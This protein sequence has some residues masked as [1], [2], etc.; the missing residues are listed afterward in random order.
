MTASYPTSTPTTLG[1]F[2]AKNNIL[3]ETTSPIGAGDTTIPILDTTD[4]PNS[5]MLTFT[6][7]NEVILYTGK[8]VSSITGVTRGYDGTSAFA[9]GA[10]QELEMR[11]NAEYHN[12]QNEEIVAVAADL[13]N[14]FSAD[15]DDTVVAVGVAT[16]IENRL[17][18]IATQ[19]K[20]IISGTDWKDSPVSSLNGLNNSK[21]AKAGDT[22]TGD[23]TLDNQHAVV[24]NELSSNGTEFVSILAPAAIGTSYSLYLPTGQGAANTSIFND[25][26]G[27]LSFGLI[28]NAN[29]HAS[30]A[31]AYSKLN[32]SAS[33]VNADIAAGAAIALNKL[34]AIT[35]N[36]MVVSDASGFLG[37][38]A[39]EYISAGGH[40]RTGSEGQ[41]QFQDSTTTQINISA[42][43][44]ISGAYS[45]KLPTAQGG[46]A[47]LMENDGSGNLSWRSLTNYITNAMIN[48]SAAIALTKLAAVTASRMLVSDGSGFI[49]A[50][51]W[52][53][54]SPHL[55]TQSGGT[56]RFVDSGSNYIQVAAPTTISA[57]YSVAWP[58]AQGGSNSFLKNDGS[59]NLSW[60]TPA[61]AGT[62]NSGLAG[63]FAYYPANGDT[64]DDQTVLYTDGTR[65]G[66][67]VSSGLSD[68][69]HIFQSG[70]PTLRLE[71][72]TSGNPSIRWINSAREW[73]DYVDGSGFR[74]IR[75][76]TGAGDRLVI[77]TNG[78]I[79]S[80]T[81]GTTSLPAWSFSSQTSM[82]WRRVSSNKI[83]YVAGTVDMVTID[84]G[85]LDLT[86][87]ANLIMASG[88]QANPILAHR[89]NTDSGI[90][91]P[92][93]LSNAWTFDNA[94]FV[95][96]RGDNSVDRGILINLGYLK[97]GT[98]GTEA[99]PILTWEAEPGTGFWRSGTNDMRLS[100]GGVARVLYFASEVN[101][102]VNTYTERAEV[103][104]TV[105]AHVWNDDNTNT[106]S[107]AK[108]FIQS[109]GTS[110]G[111]A[112]IHFKIAGSTDWSV[113]ID[114]SVNDQ[115][116][117]TPNAAVGGGSVGYWSIDTSNSILHEHPGAGSTCYLDMYASDNT[118]SLS[119][120]FIRLRTGGSSAGDPAINFL[121]QGATN[122]IIGIDN[123]D[124]DKF[125][126]AGNNIFNGSNEFVV[127]T[128]GGQH[129][130]PNGSAA[131]PAYSFINATGYGMYWN[132]GNDLNLCTAGTIALSVQTG[133]IS[134]SRDTRPSADNTYSLGV[135]GGRWTAVWAANGTIQTSHS[136]T[137]QN[138][139]DIDP[140]KVEIPRGVEY[141][142]DGRRYIGYLN[143]SIPDAGRPFDA[144]GNICAKDNYEQSV[145]G[146]LCA[147][148]KKLESEIA[149]LKAA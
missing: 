115:Y 135:S 18:M 78:Q 66:I 129:L 39:W 30:A 149:E 35:A 15:L 97:F 86:N 82:G 63:F 143:D 60:D 22:M 64:V 75:D 55:S 128:T 133:L 72:N 52:S 50:S 71:T 65:L 57:S 139:V 109:G 131:S 62:V 90:Y 96:I 141:D 51:G 121:V 145:I 23:L 10:G 20:N 87:N 146:I 99:A 120:S 77:N 118:N 28:Q 138:I 110:A 6:D 67:G 69:V 73:S 127:I 91:W 140:L 70:S 137:K 56:I 79:L 119:N 24:F 21:V 76:N 111:D 123:S 93:T 126:I 100:V 116:R 61:G 92:S 102:R 144:H 136:S 17:D 9:H 104:G 13:R 147:H 16:S 42:P 29:V 1:L 48:S 112:F 122:F 85:S 53:F 106:A 59:G 36:R 114:N 124:S 80:G 68:I 37:A 83:A 95:T 89:T 107:H 44:T 125:K 46:A 33:I 43:T 108:L 34:A 47:T 98:N 38:S 25:G 130:V 84:T 2:Q 41:L 105:I 26:S 19:L 12:R 103:G 8:T 49:I 134:C 88:S 132:G 5:G 74:I 27:N 113:G 11:W 148:V 45:L 14:A 142:R 58:T 117:I 101:H 54:S 4:L 94:T 7:N 31:I 3:V 81:D 40:L 32:L